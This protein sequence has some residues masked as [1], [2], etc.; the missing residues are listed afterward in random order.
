MKLVPTFYTL[1]VNEV[2]KDENHENVVEFNTFGPYFYIH[3]VL[4]DRDALI[5]NKFQGKAENV[6]IYSS[7]KPPKT[8]ENI[9]LQMIPAFLEPQFQ[10]VFNSNYISKAKT[11]QK[12]GLKKIKKKVLEFQNKTQEIKP[13]RKPTEYNNFIKEEMIAQRLA[14]PEYN[15]KNLFKMVAASWKTSTKNPKNG[16]GVN[17]V[18]TPSTPNTTVDG[19]IDDVDTP[20]KK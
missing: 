18:K 5:Q 12:Q 10:N 14:H 1:H 19:N 7:S 3:E 20:E 9:I 6:Q 11:K 16:E 4:A 2:S 13:K 15:H 8:H 17:T